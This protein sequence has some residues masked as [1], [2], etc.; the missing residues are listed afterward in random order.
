LQEPFRTQVKLIGSYVVPKVDVQIA[1]TLQSLP[2]REILAEYVAPN[3]VVAPSL[4]RNLAG[5]AANTTIN[6]VKA[7][8]LFGERLKQVDLRVG[9]I[10]RFGARRVSVHLD[11]FNALNDDT[12]L[13]MN[14][15]FGTWQRPTSIM[16]ARFAKISAQLDF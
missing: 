7:G 5:G 9:K 6:I 12:V 2:G 1:A 8:T 13:T 11:V 3:S 14:N 15:A 4:R 10:L 16:L